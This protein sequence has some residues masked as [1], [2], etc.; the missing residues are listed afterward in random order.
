MRRLF[1]VFLLLLA[2]GCD[3]TLPWASTEASSG[4]GPDGGSG[5]LAVA[6]GSISVE[7]TPGGATPAPSALALTITGAAYL[8]VQFSG[9]AVANAVLGGS[10]GARV[11]TVTFPSPG[12]APVVR[13][14]SV[15]VIACTDASCSAQLQGSPASVPV[16]Y[17][18]TPGL[19]ANPSSLTAQWTRGD[20]VPELPAVALAESGVTAGLATADITYAGASGWLSATS[21]GIPGSSTVTLAPAGLPAGVQSATIRYTST[22]TKLVNVPVSFT[23][24]E[25]TVTGTP[26]TLAFDGFIG[27]APPS[28][29]TSALTAGAVPVTYTVSVDYGAGASGWLT[30]PPAVTPPQDLSVAPNT[31]ALAAGAHTATV[32]F[33]SGDGVTCGTLEVSYTL[34]A[35]NLV[36]PPD[37]TLVV[38]AAA[39]PGDLAGSAPVDVS[40]GPALAWTASSSAAWLVLD[41][42]SGTTGEDVDYHLDPTILATMGHGETKT[43]AVTVSASVSGF[44][45]SFDV[46]LENRLPE[47]RYVMPSVQ[48]SGA[49]SRVRIRGVGFEGIADPSSLQP[50][51]ELGGAVVSRLSDTAL[52]VDLPSA[53][54]GDRVVRIPNAL[55]LATRS[56]VLHHLAPATFTYA[57]VA[58]AGS[59]RAL[60]LDARRQAVLAVNS[61]QGS[62]VRFAHSGGTWTP[63]VRAIA[64]IQDLGLSPDGELLV[65]VSSSAV[66]LLDPVTLDDVQT[67]PAPAG[68]SYLAMSESHG[69]AVMNDG[70]VALPGVSGW[71]FSLRTF[72]LGTRTFGTV[73]STGV[74]LSLY[75]GP[76]YGFSRDGERV[77]VVQSASISPSPPLLYLDA[78]DG[79]ARTNPAGLTF[80]YQSSLSDDGSRSILGSR[81]VY[82]GS[83]GNVGSVTL[84]ASTAPPGAYSIAVAAMAP[85]GSHAYVLA[86]PPGYGGATP[87]PAKVFVLDTRAVPTSGLDLPI[88]R[89]FDVPDYVSCLTGGYGCQFRPYLAVSPDDGTLFVVG[90]QGLLVVPIPP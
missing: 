75:S 42:A 33:R 6:P 56:A 38:T 39:V 76:W 87:P 80:F 89:S 36:D 74:S 26:A 52:V 57:K 18:V 28:S 60:V 41:V 35:V 81:L 86:Y 40:G 65:A 71:T 82:D 4:D 37:R 24:R 53:T 44:T 43:A 9:A 50:V 51:E 85:D 79:K 72:D 64:G 59:K 1:A 22:T 68:A 19:Q 3:M 23:V 45:Q 5:S 48:P 34:E 30:L 7:A 90:A 31:T 88:L 49:A 62:V 69:L 21:A 66:R 11:V 14:G 84:P 77:L 8:S 47:V 13:T 78:T 20:S 32:L 54:A 58:Q 10:V 61:E 29:S 12:G 46:T 17:T 2:S 27:A 55:G 83:F 73:D 15:T 67:Y 25:P 70:R 16:T 63:T